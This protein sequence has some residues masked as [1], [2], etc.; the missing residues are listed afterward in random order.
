M[1]PF[2]GL[3]LLLLAL[4]LR[5]SMRRGKQQECIVITETDVII[6]AQVGAKPVTTRFSRHWTRVKL[7]APLSTLHPSR[8]CME[9]GGRACEVG[10]FL[11]EEER[12]ALTARLEQLVGAMNSSPSLERRHA[13]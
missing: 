1:L 5:H 12:S 3:E 6:S 4:V 10:S 2:A 13:S 9:S 7:R 11:T 8:L